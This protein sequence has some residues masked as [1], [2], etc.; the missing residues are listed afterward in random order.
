MTQP[1]VQSDYGNIV[2]G[3]SG[4]DKWL[5]RFSAQQRSAYEE[6]NADAPP[7]ESF[8]RPLSVG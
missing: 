5:H 7:R 2:G 1:V 8:R 4:L 6:R 3:D